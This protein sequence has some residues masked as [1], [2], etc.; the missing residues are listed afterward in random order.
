[1]KSSMASY[2][3]I[4]SVLIFINIQVNANEQFITSNFLENKKTCIS[5]PGQCLIQIEN[6]I[7]EIKKHSTQWYSLVNLK[8]LAIWELRDINW[9]V[10]ETH[11]YVNL[12][13]APPVFLTTVYTLHAK[14]LFSDGN[15][16]QGTLYA[17][18][19]VDLIKKVNNISFDADRYAEIII[20]YNQLNQK[21][22]AKEFIHWINERIAKMGPDHYFPKLQTA[23]AHTY[24]QIADYDFALKH[25]QYALKGFIETKYELEIAE[26]YHNIARAFQG[27]KEYNQ[28]IP[29]FNKALTWMNS[30]VDSGNYSVEAKNYTQLRLIE[31]FQQNSQYM[32][33]KLLL[34]EIKPDEVSESNLILYQLLKKNI[35]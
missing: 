17:N 35:D 31:T 25:Y 14:T 34:K 16:K 33:A 24:I 3:F 21:D 27:K 8:L 30:A 7:G 2:V 4:C 26:S 22:K 20:L 23:I 1:M 15:I 19:S 5:T 6:R 9:L 18:K 32:K 28:A 12:N 11:K 13:N 29:F 10:K